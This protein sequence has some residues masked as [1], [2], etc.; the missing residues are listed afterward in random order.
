MTPAVATYAGRGVYY[1]PGQ[2]AC[3]LGGVGERPADRSNRL[4]L[5]DPWSRATVRRDGATIHLLNTR[6]Y[7]RQTLIGDLLLMGRGRTLDGKEVPLAFHT[8]FEKKGDRF[9]A[10]PHLHPTVNAPL[11]DACWEPFTVTL[12]NGMDAIVAIDSARL[13][14]AWRKPPLASRLGRALIQVDDHAGGDRDPRLLVDVV[15]SLGVGLLRKPAV[16]VQVARTDGPARVAAAA[17]GARDLADLFR[18]GSWELRLRALM[19]LPAARDHV[20]RA[21]FLFGLEHLPPLERI[22]AKGLRH[23]Q[24]LTFGFCQGDGWIGVSPQATLRTDTASTEDRARV[25]HAADVARAYL[26]LDFVGAILAQQMRE[27]LVRGD[28]PPERARAQ[29]QAQAQGQ[30]LTL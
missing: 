22:A 23:G 12:S 1:L 28:C 6:R 21:F 24:T 9:D 29:A 3:P 7:R 17:T 14:D 16:R 13:N 18:D 5:D 11:A 27:R 8:R 26:E 2:I 20:Q 10:R 19:N 15:V 4:V 25:A 30:T